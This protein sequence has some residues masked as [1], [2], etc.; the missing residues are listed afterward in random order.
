MFCCY[1]LAFSWRLLL[2]KRSCRSLPPCTRADL[3]GMF[4]SLSSLVSI[5]SSTLP[6]TRFAVHAKQHR[7]KYHAL[8]LTES[9][10]CRGMESE[11]NGAVVHNKGRLPAQDLVASKTHP[12]R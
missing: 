3:R 2:A 11:S 6:H 1:K 9:T 4:L 7:R 10:Q 8:W 12:A 5:I